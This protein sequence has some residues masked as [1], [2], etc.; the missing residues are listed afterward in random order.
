MQ[1]TARTSFLLPAYN[2]EALVGRAVASIRAAAERCGLGSYEI[3]VCD[4]ASTDRTADIAESAGAR[5]V[6]ES[7]RQIARARNAA[8]AASTG[9]RL[10]WLDADAMLTPE[11]LRATQESFA[12]GRFCG[13]GA[14][15]ELEGEVLGW[16]ARRTVDTWNWI[17][18]T[19]RFAAGSYVFARRDAWAETGGFNEEVYAGEEIG[20]ARELKRWGKARGLGF[21]VLEHPVPSSARK[22]RQFT[23]RQTLWQLAVCAW[24]G[25]LGRRDRCSFWYERRAGVEG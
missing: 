19:F 10:V 12:C 21:R 2:E 4:N 24:P 18:R 9:M 22:V 13:G 7:H 3:V 15:V 16:S 25:N 20:F 5:V 11:V 14:Q 1:D 23:L 17:A 8:A 6:H